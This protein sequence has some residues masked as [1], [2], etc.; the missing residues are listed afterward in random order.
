MNWQLQKE[1]NKLKDALLPVIAKGDKTLENKIAGLG[2]N[3][4]DVDTWAN[5]PTVDGM[6]KP[7]SANDVFYLTQ[8]D[9]NHPAGMYRRKADNSDWNDTPIIDFDAIGISAII[10]SAKAG[11]VV[12][13][14]N[15]GLATATEDSKF[16]TPK[17]VAKVVNDFKTAIDGIYHPKGGDVNLKVVGKDADENT[18]EYVTANQ[19]KVT[20]TET[21]L[22]AEYDTVYNSL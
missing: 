19:S 17:E 21:D 11:D 3:V 22:Q 18:Q 7:L 16:T 14:D 5:R 9:G 4:A 20:Y 10:E 13:I 2:T 8:K 6:G 12:T 1:I 15:T